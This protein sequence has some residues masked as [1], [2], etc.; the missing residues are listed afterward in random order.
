D[1]A[2]TTNLLNDTFMRFEPSQQIGWRVSVLDTNGLEDLNEIRIELGNDGNLG[3]KY[4]TLDD[5]CSALDE[6]L[7][8]VPSGC[9]VNVQNNILTVEFT[10]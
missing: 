8:L 5:T 7:L 6:R 10:A 4:T 9:E 3:V 1:F 2:P